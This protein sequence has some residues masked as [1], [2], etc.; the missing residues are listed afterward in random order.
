M[1]EARFLPGAISSDVHTLSIN[2]R[3][4]T[5]GSRC[6]ISCPRNGSRGAGRADLGCLSVG[7][8]GDASVLELVEG[9]FRYRDVLGRYGPVGSS[10]RRAGWWSAADGGIRRG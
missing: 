2:G 5:S 9:E 3:R 6:R 7:A 8:V 1:L 4:S 10:S